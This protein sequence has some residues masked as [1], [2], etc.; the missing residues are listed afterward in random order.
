MSKSVAPPTFF[1][2]SIGEPVHLSP[3]PIGDPVQLF[4]DPAQLHPVWTQAWLNFSA[5]CYSCSLSKN[6]RI[7]IPMDPLSITASVV[8]LVTIASKLAASL[9]ALRN[10]FRSAPHEIDSIS[11]EVLSLSVVLIRLQR[12]AENDALTSVELPVEDGL[13]EVL[14]SCREILDKIERKVSAIS[15]LLTGHSFVR[16]KQRWSWTSTKKDLRDLCMRLEYYKTA[17]L[18]L[19]QLRNL[20]VQI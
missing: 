15:A 12:L 2:R 1:R 20:Y 5:K 9:V 19:L 17:I 14:R 18:M 8:T 13:A 7:R 11:K 10:G 4:R 16:V 3:T 6:S